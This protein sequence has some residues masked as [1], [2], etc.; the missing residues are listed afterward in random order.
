MSDQLSEKQGGSYSLLVFGVIQRGC[1]VD[2][3]QGFTFAL[4]D[5]REECSSGAGFRALA[6]SAGSIIVVSPAE[7]A[8]HRRINVDKWAI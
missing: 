3:R 1:I 5:V 6:R 4:N 7:M 2:A 8:P